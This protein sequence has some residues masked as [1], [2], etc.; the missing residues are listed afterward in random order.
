MGEITSPETLDSTG[1][2]RTQIQNPCYG[3]QQNEDFQC[4]EDHD[5]D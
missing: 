5:D 1:G 4:L 3:G 2:Q